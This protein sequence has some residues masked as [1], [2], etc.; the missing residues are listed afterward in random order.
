MKTNHVGRSSGLTRAM[1]VVL[2]ASIMLGLGSS[3]SIAENPD[4]IFM[5]IDALSGADE[6]RYKMGYDIAPGGFAATGWQDIIHT[7]GP[8]NSTSG[9]G[10]TIGYINDNEIPDLI[11]MCIDDPEGNNAFRYRIGWDMQHTG[12]LNGALAP[13]SW[14]TRSISG[15]GYDNKGGGAALA[16]INGNDRPDLILMG[17]DDPPGVNNFWYKMGWD[18]DT[19]GNAVSW[20]GKITVGGIGNCTS[21]GGVAVAYIDK[22]EIPDLILMGVDNPDG[23]DHFRYRIGWNLDADGQTSEWGTVIQVD[24]PAL[25]PNNAGGGAAIGY[26]NGNARPDLILMGINDGIQ[27][28]PFIDYPDDFY[29]TIGWDLGEDGRTSDWRANTVVPGIGNLTA[30]G[31]VAI[32]SKPLME[33]QFTEPLTGSNEKINVTRSKEAR[34]KVAVEPSGYEITETYW[35]H[36]SG[37]TTVEHGSVAGSEINLTFPNPGDYTLYCRVSVEIGE[38]QEELKFIS[39]PI[40]VWNPPTVHDAPPQDNMDAGDVSWYDGKYV[41]V[42]GHPVRLMAEASTENDDPDEEISHFLWDLNNS[43]STVELEQPANEVVSYV[44]DTSHENAQI[45]CKAVTNYGVE[46]VESETKTFN[47]KIYD[48]VQVDPGGPYTG[49][50]NSAVE[51]AGSMGNSYQNATVAY[52][53][54]VNSVT[55]EPVLSGNATNMGDYMRLTE[56]VNSEKGHV[57]YESLPLSDSWSV[58]G[59]FWSGDGTGADAFYIYVWANGVPTLEYEN[60]GQYTIVFDEYQDQIQFY[61]AS[62]KLKTESQPIPIDNSQWRPFRV[63]FD[64]GAFEVYLD[65]RLKLEYDVGTGYQTRKDN[66]IHFGFGARTDVQNNIHRVRKMKWTPGDPVETDTRGEAEYTWTSEATHLAGFTVRVTTS[67]GLVL[68]ETASVEVQV[69]AGMPTA[70]PGGPYRGGIAGGDFSPIPFEG[71]HPDFIE[72]DDVGKIAEW[73]WFFPDNGNGAL[74]LDGQ[75]DY[76]IVNSINSFPS[77]SLTVEFW[78]KSSDN[79]RNGTPISYASTGSANDFYIYNYRDFSFGITGVDSRATGISANDGKWHHIAVTWQSVDGLFRFYKD[80]AKVDSATV[81]AG[82]FITQG[83]AFVI[84]QKQGAVGGDFGPTQVFKGRIDE[85]MVWSEVRSADQIR[86]D[87]TGDLTGSE[88]QPVLYYKFEEGEGTVAVDETGQ[89]HGTLMNTVPEAWVDDGHPF[90]PKS[91]WNPSHNYPFAGTYQAGLKVL[92]ASG[93]WSATATADV[94]VIDG[95]IAGYVRAADLR[96]PVREVRLILTS[97]HV[98]QDALALAVSLDS[99]LYTEAGGLWTETDATGRYAFPHLPLGSYRIVATKGEGDAAH[100][101]EKT[102]QATELT[103]N[104]PNQLAIDFVDLSVFP[105]GGRIV[106]S[107]QKNGQDVLVDGVEVTAQPIGSTFGISALPSTKSLTATGTNYSLPLFAGKYL[108][109]PRKEGH[110]VRIKE[111]TPGYDSNTGLVMLEGARTDVD[112]INHTTRTLTVYVEDSGGNPITHYPDNYSNAGDSIVVTVSGLN[113]QVSGEQIDSEAKL[114]TTLNPGEY[115]VQIEYGIPKGEDAEGPAEVNLT[116]DDGSVTMIIP[117]QIELSFVIAEDDFTYK[118]KLFDV[119][120]EAFLEQFGL[121]ADDNPEGYMYYYPPEPRTHTYTIQ[122]TANGQPVKNFTLF[123]KDNVS[124]M[125]VDE[126]EEQNAEIL[127]DYKEEAEHGKTEYTIL[128]GL[129]KQTDDTPPL[130]APKTVRFRAEADGYENSDTVTDSVIVL[131]E[132]AKGSA[133]KIVSIPIVNYTVLHDPPGDGSY[134]F[135]DDTMIS[136]G[137]ITDMQI[138]MNDEVV[139]VYPSPWSS[140]RTIEGFEFENDP[141]S[142]SEFKDLEDKG[143]LSYEDPGSVSHKFI[144]G[145]LYH[146]G[147]GT[148]F[149]AKG[150]LSYAL[151]L[152]KLGITAWKI[153]TGDTVPGQGYF[154]QYEVSPNRRLQTPSGDCLPDLVGPGKGDL[155]FGEGWTLGLQTKYFMG[156]LWNDSTEEWDLSTDE[157]ET[158]DILDVDNQYIYTVRDIENIKSDL[159]KTVDEIGDDPDRASEKTKLQKAY[160]TWNTLLGDNL[161]YVWNRDYVPWLHDPVEGQK[162]S[163]EDFMN[164]RGSSMGEC[165][166]LIFSAG[167]AFEYSRRIFEGDYSSYSIRTGIDAASTIS[168]ESNVSVGFKAWGAGM[169]IDFKLGSSIELTGTHTLGREWEGGKSTEQTVGFVLQDDDVGDNIAVRVNADPRWGTPIF[170]QD[171]GSYTSDPWESGTNKAVDFT[172]EMIEDTTGTFDYYEGAHY[173]V[174]LKYTGQR[175]LESSGSIDFLRYDYLTDEHDNP[176]VRFNGDPALYR[177]KLS[178]QT[179]IAT[180]NVSIYPAEI[181]RGRSEEKLYTVKIIAEEEGD[182]HINRSVTMTP[183]FAD[184][185]APRAIIAAPYEGE[186]ISPVFF[187]AEDPFDIEV[188]SGDWDLASIQLQIRSKQPD[189]VWEPWSNLFGMLWEDGGTNGNVTVFDRLDRRPPR[190]EFVFTWE[191]DKIRSLGVG[192]Y[193]LRAIATDKATT[194]NRDM[195]PPFVVFLVDESEPSVLNSIPDY[196]ARESERIYRGELSVTFTDDMRSTDFSDRTFYVTDLLDNNTK[197]AGYVSYSPALRKTGF[198]PIVPFRPNGFYRVEIKTDVDTDGDG[199]MDERGVHDL[200]GNPLDNAFMW[201]FRTT[202]APFEPIWSMVFS[203]TD[204]ASKDANKYA[205][206]EYGALDQEDEKD[207]RAVPGLANQLRMVFLNRDQV[208]FERDIRPADGRLSHHWFFVIDNAQSGALVTIDWQPSIRLTKTTRQYQVIRLV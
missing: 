19:S 123:V 75:D 52:Q 143:L 57:D 198:V 70:M 79:S 156:I 67:E 22:N 18:L 106:Y 3:Y 50:V 146:V 27:I 17:I 47:L 86:Q 187:P 159:D 170:F 154:V 100:E 135:L 8:G 132:V 138:R 35:K 74:E 33:A 109:F 56:A 189:G 206:V 204:G 82:E 139:P 201:T 45:R 129:P 148:V 171:P 207:A 147:M 97:T 31:G 55:P 72:A 32:I 103:L 122:A 73:T 153:G 2:A 39:I 172:M 25:G 164:E 168:N 76:V 181:D 184:L 92:A 196:Q 191:E 59:E 113:G 71:N 115:T 119:E 188:L 24:S 48:T 4:L 124:M 65:Y 177:V 179:P 126:A 26:V 99:T 84:G 182:Q 90:I 12:I 155:Y 87:M 136:K 107:I 186:R 1:L 162:K 7:G 15:L 163:F 91:V 85:V 41:G 165:N 161:A 118:P 53:W 14:S 98:T 77:D 193:A 174:K 20:G 68:E 63:V 30:G 38:R 169:T 102:V 61:D 176:T 202:D 192:E 125:T 94:E 69:E 64:H 88:T 167:P 120:S 190:R 128:G 114:E 134:S 197:V 151:K 183:T 83:G 199:M 110:D 96:T 29:Y 173:K 142:D 105:V 81:A 93:K 95:K 178:K 66:N 104:G 150:P 43:W 195:D 13:A 203:V 130:A 9:G 5:G 62:T 160:N 11:L 158:Y 152:A 131:G 137:I 60:K 78:M 194:P 80:G 121:T 145:G 144:I 101:F 175:E 54:R 116:S 208:Q 34:F 200:A 185:R 40:R 89:N 127:T 157:V 149:V 141:D 46:S 10:A 140:E 36:V 111:D 23:A 180:V 16:Y 108:F 133:A 28:P 205:A 49:R 117:V 44:W 21:G 6:F 58:T 112:F 51:L 42:K 37:T 166:M